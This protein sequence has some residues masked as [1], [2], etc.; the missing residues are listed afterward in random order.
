MTLSE[1]IGINGKKDSIRITKGRI[2]KTVALI[3]VVGLCVFLLIINFGFIMLHS[4]NI[5]LLVYPIG[6]FLNCIIIVIFTI[7]VVKKIL[8][9]GK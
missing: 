6:A 8:T 2:G 7:M 1:R 9:R 3:G 4:G 5:Q